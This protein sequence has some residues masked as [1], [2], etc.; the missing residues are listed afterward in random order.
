VI[1]TADELVTDCSRCQGL[2]C[3]ATGF[4]RSADFPIDKPPGVPC[5]NLDPDF[6]CRVHDAL[7]ALGFRGCVRFD[8]LGAGVRVSRAAGERTWRE[9][10]AFSATLFAAFARMRALHELLFYLHEARTRLA[11]DP[12]HASIDAA[13]A[14]VEAVCSGALE[15]LATLDVDAVR[16]RAAP[17]LRTASER[18]RSASPGPRLDLAGK[19]LIGKDLTRKDLRGASLRGAL[20]IGAR[21]DGLDLSLADFTGADVRDASARGARLDG[22]LFL[23]PDQRRD[24]GRGEP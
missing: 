19:D 5:S 24:L 21:L 14:G 20:L 7:P 4:S 1:P 15:D 17:L 10:P 23:R 22:A 8:C 11:D 18:L 16:S 3:V 13:L 6:R 12:L 9:H 2:C